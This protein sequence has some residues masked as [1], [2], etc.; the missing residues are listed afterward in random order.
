MV[1]HFYVC[2]IILK[3]TQ[4]LSHGIQFWSSFL[5]MVVH[6]ML[7]RTISSVTFELCLCNIRMG[8]GF[9]SATSWTEGVYDYESLNMK[10]I[11]AV[12]V[13]QGKQ[14]RSK[15]EAFAL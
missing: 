14:L 15:N 4:I 8:T 7:S 11:S 3:L 2:F 10:N 6:T 9:C 13:D 12:R 5:V 1:H